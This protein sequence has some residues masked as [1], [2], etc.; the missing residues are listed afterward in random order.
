MLRSFVELNNSVLDR[1]GDKER[2]RIGVHSCPGGD[3]D[4]TH[5]ADVD[6]AGLLPLLFELHAGAFYLEPAGERDP[7]AVLAAIAANMQPG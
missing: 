5:S 2:Q 6:Y 7:E 3:H 1:F 4:S